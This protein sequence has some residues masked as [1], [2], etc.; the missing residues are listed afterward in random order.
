MD[1]CN[2]TAIDEGL[3]EI[4]YPF[5]Y[6]GLSIKDYAAKTDDCLEIIDY[7]FLL[8]RT[9][10]FFFQVQCQIGVTRRRW[11]DF[12]V[13]TTRDSFCETINFNEQFW[14]LSVTKACSFYNIILKKLFM[15]HIKKESESALFIVLDMLQ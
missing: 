7:R 2:A 9:H 3:L 4:K 5:T 14:N 10:F 13:S 6:R 15:R 1:L 11:C 12:L 8:K